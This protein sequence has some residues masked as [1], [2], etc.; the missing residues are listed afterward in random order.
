MKNRESVQTFRKFAL[1]SE[2]ENCFHLPAQRIPKEFIWRHDSSQR[3][4]SELLAF[5]E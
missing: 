4:H 3:A 5:E 1:L 2:K